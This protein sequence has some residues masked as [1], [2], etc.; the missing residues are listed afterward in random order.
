MFDPKDLKDIPPEVLEEMG[1]NTSEQDLEVLE[2]LAST[3][4]SMRKEA[5]DER[6]VSGIEEVWLAAEEAYIWM[7]DAN[8]GEFSNARWAK[9]MAMNGPLTSDSGSRDAVKS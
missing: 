7:D 4:S 5:I 9:P 6:R 2:N 1:I 8:R 3:I